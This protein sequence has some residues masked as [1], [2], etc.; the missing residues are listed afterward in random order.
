VAPLLGADKTWLSQEDWDALAEKLRPYESWIGSRPTSSVAKLGLA[1]VNAILSGQGRKALDDLFGEDKTLAP[2]VAAIADVERLA[3]FCRDL[4]T[5]LR[6]F[7]NFSDF[8]SM[9]RP[10]VFQAGKLYMDGRS[11]SL[12]IRVDDIASHATF[13]AMSQVY[14]AY[15]ECRRPGAETMRIAAGVTQGDSD[16]LFVGRNGVFYD[17]KVRDWDATVVK[18]V[19][20]PISIRQS[21]W[22]PYKRVASFVGDQFAKLA[23]S[24]DKLVQTGMNAAVTKVATQVV[25]VA[26]AAPPP[27]FDI[28]K[29][30]GIFAA[31]GLALS[32]IGVALAAVFKGIA[33]LPLLPLWMAPLIIALVLL[34]ISGPSMIIAYIRLRQRNLGPLLEGTGWAVNGR[35]KINVPL[36][37]TLTDRGKLPADSKRLSYDPY[38]DTAAKGRSSAA[39]ALVIA[40]IAWLAVAKV[41]HYW[42][43]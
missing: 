10:A 2:R 14:V 41:Y 21:F 30:A 12:C 22:A 9:A 36:G 43:F 32:A 16:Y 1:R 4:G 28:G 38:E 7:V 5:L 37:A 35:V 19:D 34:I 27:P 18:I 11:C 29:F 40:V 31:M 8:Y 39:V 20:S 6:N 3:L 17:R 23:A 25:E 26:P 24:K 33:S 42:P 13:A 15:L